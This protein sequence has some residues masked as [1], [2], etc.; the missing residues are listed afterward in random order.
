MLNFIPC[1]II[2]HNIYLLKIFMNKSYWFLCYALSHKNSAFQVNINWSKLMSLWHILPTFVS[3]EDRT[4]ILIVNTD[5]M[6]LFTIFNMNIRHEQKIKVVNFWHYI[7]IVNIQTTLSKLQLLLNMLS[8]G[9]KQIII[10]IWHIQR[11]ITYT[12]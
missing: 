11:K 5:L 7:F 12:L 4:S 1:I 2:K 8:K 9:G 6:N 3:L 10:F